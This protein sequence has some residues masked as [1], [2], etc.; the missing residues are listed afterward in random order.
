M[1]MQ[2]VEF[3]V[4]NENYDKD[5]VIVVYVIGDLCYQISLAQLL[6]S[7]LY[8]SFLFSSSFCLAGLKYYEVCNL[9]SIHS[10]IA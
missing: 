4:R 8:S 5:E 9:W 3:D 2:E 1:F 7:Y 10:R 6:C